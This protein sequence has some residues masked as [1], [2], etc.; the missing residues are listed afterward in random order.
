MQDPAPLEQWRG[1]MFGPKPGI[2]AGTVQER[3]LAICRDQHDGGGSADTAQ[4]N[5]P[6]GID[7]G[8]GERSHQELVF[9]DGHHDFCRNAQLGE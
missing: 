3:G 6:A 8:A 7:P 5:Q 4:A 1:K 9:P 2:G